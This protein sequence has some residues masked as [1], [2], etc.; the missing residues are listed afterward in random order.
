MNTGERK[1]QNIN[2]LQHIKTNVLNNKTWELKADESG[3]SENPK[4]QFS[5]GMVWIL[6]SK[7]LILQTFTSSK[8]EFQLRFGLLLSP[9]FSHYAPI[10]TILPVPRTKNQ[11][12]FL[13]TTKCYR[14]GNLRRRTHRQ[15]QQTLCSVSWWFSFKNHN[16][17]IHSFW[18][19][20]PRPSKAGIT[21]RFSPPSGGIL[22]PKTH[23]G[24]YGDIW[25]FKGGYPQSS[26]IFGW[27][28]PWNKPS[29]ARYWGTP[30]TME[31]PIILV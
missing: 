10:P 8:S 16:P 12:W 19:A 4:T 15:I 23:Y 6:T 31:T 30:M 25:G 5:T 24:H 28:F 27:D 1:R 7:E 3:F 18:S 13:E 26:S 22:G 9:Y 21:M 20:V 11:R 29:N 14:A 17:R 2:V